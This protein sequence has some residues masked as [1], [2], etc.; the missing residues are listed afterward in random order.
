MHIGWRVSTSTAHYIYSKTDVAHVHT[1]LAR[2]LMERSGVL[3]HQNIEIL[4]N[5]LSRNSAKM[6]TF[7][8][9]VE[10]LKAAFPGPNEDDYPDL[11]KYLLEHLQALA[12]VRPKEIGLLSVSQ[13]QKVRTGSVADQAVMWHAY[14]RIA[15]LLISDP[16]W[17]ERLNVLR[18]KYTHTRGEEAVW[19]GDLFSRENPVWVEREVIVSGKNGPRVVNNRQSRQGAF[20][21][22]RDL[23]QIPASASHSSPQLNVEETRIPEPV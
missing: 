1:K 18:G 22:L 11:L 12:E 6:L 13:R 5:H 19:T 17:R 3:G 16:I 20:E 10:A 9:L 14:I 15:S 8:T 7:G 21:F 4:S 23:L 2:E